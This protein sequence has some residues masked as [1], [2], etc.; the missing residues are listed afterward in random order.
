MTCLD[1]GEE[2]LARGW[3][4]LALCPPSHC[5]VPRAHAASCRKP[6]K[7]PLRPWARLH[8]SRQ[9]PRELRADFGRHP[10]A[11][12]GVVLG[13]VSGLV[14]VDCDD[15]S[16]F[17]AVESLL[18]GDVPPGVP[19]FRT[20]RGLRLLFSTPEGGVP[21]VSG[22]LPGGAEL[23]AAGRQTVMPPSAHASGRRYSWLSRPGPHAPR[24]L[25]PALAA[26]ARAADKFP[27]AGDGAPIADGRKRRL[28]HLACSLRRYGATPGE[29][30][31][32]LGVFNERCDP[33]LPGGKLDEIAASASRYGPRY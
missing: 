12:V 26:S 28:F 29:I 9:T 19:S 32:C 5:G 11:N 25:P 16:S 3:S 30:R 4:A 15:E 2:Y 24:P 6:G 14:G 21:C 7:V 18:G 1:A 22:L 31:L 17:A 13:P 33:P 8:R 20:G 23:L 10:N 27:P